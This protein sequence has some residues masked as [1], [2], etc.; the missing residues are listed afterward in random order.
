[1]VKT[2]Q[3]LV[4]YVTERDFNRLYHEAA[5]LARLPSGRG[6]PYEPAEWW[7]ALLATGLLTGWRIRELLALRWEDVDFAT[8]TIITRHADNKGRRDERVPIHDVVIEH[9]K[10]LRTTGSHV[11]P[12]PHSPK[13]LWAEFG[14]I[15]KAIG[16]NLVCREAHVHTDACHVYSFHDL[17][18]AF[19]T[20][21]A[22]QMKPETLQILMRHKAYQTTLGYVNRA[23]QVEEAV[24]HLHVPDVLKPRTTPDQTQAPEGVNGLFTSVVVG[25]W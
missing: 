7:R 19:A 20:L 13:R 4:V 11:F 8:A 21:N 3:K 16:I 22:K 2:P 10:R 5:W 18:R 14:R 23:E 15:Q 1:M 17:R 9:L 12:W 24:A 25:I 6:Q